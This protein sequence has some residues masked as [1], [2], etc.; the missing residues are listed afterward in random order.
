MTRTVQIGS[1]GGRP[2]SS[3]KDVGFGLGL[4]KLPDDGIIRDSDGDEDAVNPS[5]RPSAA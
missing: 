1:A 4:D 5:G 2:S 3:H